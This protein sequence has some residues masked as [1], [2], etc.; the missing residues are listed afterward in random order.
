[1]NNIVKN[2]I[3][4]IEKSYLNS[5]EISH[6]KKYAQFFTPKLIAEFMSKWIIESGG[7]FFLD[8]AVGT[9]VFLRAVLQIKKDISVKCYDIDSNI[10]SVT[11]NYVSQNNLKEQVK[12]ICK[13]YMFN[14][15]NNRYDGIICNPPY[16]KFH[17]FYNKNEALQEFQIRLGMTLSGF[18][19]IY[20]LFLLKSINQLNLNG[21]AAYIIPS[22]FLNSD[23]GKP[24]KR[25]LIDNRTLRYIIIFNYDKI[26]FE[27]ALT[28]SSIF[29]FSND[30]N[31]KEVEFIT[32]NSV[33]DLE[34]LS[35]QLSFY[36]DVS[37]KS[38]KVSFANLD[39][40]I[41]WRN[42]YQGTVKSKYK[43][44]VPFSN[45]AK[46]VRGIAT[47]ANEYF[48]FNLEKKKSFSIPSKYL[49][50]CISKSNQIKNPFFTYNDFLK[51][52]NKNQNVFLIDPYDA[53][54]DSIRSYLKLGEKLE[55]HKK[56]LT[57][58]RTPWYSLENRPPSPI[59]VGVFNRGGLRF[60]RNEA[61]IKNLTTF[62]CIYINA[63]FSENMDLIFSYLLTDIA[64]AVFNDNRR[65]YGGGLEKFE[66]N[67]LNSS[68]LFDFSMLTKIERDNILSLYQSYR[69]SCLA[70]KPNLQT[71]S[72]INNIYKEFLESA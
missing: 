27:D 34:E 23:Y 35:S 46:V 14:D 68:Y 39:N 38:V 49:I 65:E 42:Y 47:G 15:W 28:T 4:P 52:Q 11:K 9:G 7:K 24:V 22:E 44:L 62:H 5:S 63:L 70:N 19:N 41:K 71:L 58:H 10:L 66:P 37:L 33:E 56:Y 53:K 20:T 8:P 55:I 18:S 36:P 40:N 61:N 60:I 25:Y 21:R 17:D 31:Q 54:D 26:I 69:E 6:R 64:R 1:M 12:I 16:L 45:Y 48:T 51:L 43:L 50:P 2:N 59:W 3:D 32:V 67:D 30:E 29:L 72:L 13:D 57:S